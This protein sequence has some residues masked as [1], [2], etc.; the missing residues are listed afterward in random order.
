MD[1][2]LSDM[3]SA[4]VLM[5][6]PTFYVR[7]LQ[8]QGLNKT[9]TSNMRLFVSGS[10]PML[11]E[12]HKLWQE[13][14][15]HSIIERYGMSETNM[16]TSN[17]YDGERKAGTVG[18][19]LPNVEVVVADPESGKPLN[20]GE[21]GSVEIRGPNVFSGYWNMP[22]KTAEEIR[23]NGFFISGDLGVYGEDGYLSIVGRSKDL[24]ISGGYNIYP[25]GVRTAHR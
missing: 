6:V 3:T 1:S 12:T 22:E 20:P 16:N 15:G 17:P 24:V 23:E 19:P 13:K 11:E 7:L 8:A 18:L 14:T 10:A 2:I 21:V 4:T 5:G 9:T 25:K